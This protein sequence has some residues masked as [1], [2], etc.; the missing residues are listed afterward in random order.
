VGVAKV[1]LVSGHVVMLM[2]LVTM[3]GTLRVLVMVAEARVKTV[4]VAVPEMGVEV[5]SFVSKGGTAE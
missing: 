4:C 5:L 2:M 1:G 3:V